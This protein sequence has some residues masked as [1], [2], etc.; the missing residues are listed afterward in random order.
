MTRPIFRPKLN[1][2]PSM[3]QTLIKCCSIMRKLRQSTCA[4]AKAAALTDCDW[5]SAA[6]VDLHSILAASCTSASSASC[7]RLNEANCNVSV[8]RSFASSASTSRSFSFAA[9]TYRSEE[10]FKT[11]PIV[12]HFPRQRLFF[13]RIIGYVTPKIIYFYH[14]KILFWIK[15]S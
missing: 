10:N 14:L 11:K 12:Y 15:V 3:I 4:V 6:C 5:T 13:S 2:W 7:N 9:S 8:C 1:H